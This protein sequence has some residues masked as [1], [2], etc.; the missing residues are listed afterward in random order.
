MPGPEEKKPIDKAKAAVKFIKENFPDEKYP[1]VAANCIKMLKA[2][3]GNLIKDPENEKF[4]KINKE[5][6]AF[7]ER[8]AN[9]QGGVVFLKAI[10]FED[11]QTILEVGKV[12]MEL[13]KAAFELLG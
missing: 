2:Y 9:T 13:I 1:D 8:V 11:K 4:R 5:N 3:V 6:K 7:K 12:D 10:G